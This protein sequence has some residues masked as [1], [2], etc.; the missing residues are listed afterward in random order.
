MLVVS[1]AVAFAL[2]P[3]PQAL[4]TAA[5]QPGEDVPTLESEARR[6]GVPPL[7]LRR[8][9]R[10]TSHR[11]RVS[12]EDPLYCFKDSLSIPSR[13]RMVCHTRLQWQNAGFEPILP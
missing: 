5:F 6:M 1:L 10:A 12:L 3:I 2:T 13:P 11:E 7:A 4:V 8:A 9:L